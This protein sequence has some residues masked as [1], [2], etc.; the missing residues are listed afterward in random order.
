MKILEK[1]GYNFPILGSL[2]AIGIGTVAL[3]LSFILWEVGGFGIGPTQL[4]QM[5]ALILGGIVFP[6]IIF[7]LNFL[8]DRKILQFN[9]IHFIFGIT[10]IALGIFIIIVSAISIDYLIEF[11]ENYFSPADPGFGISAGI[12]ICFYLGIIAMLICSYG[13]IQNVMLHLKNK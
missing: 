4:F 12:L 1:T 11:A 7:A 9:N 10:T 3:I 6:G 8:A 5:I 13:G 2:L